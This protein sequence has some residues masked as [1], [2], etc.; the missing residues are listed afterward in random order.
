MLSDVIFDDMKQ[1][2][3]DKDQ[4]KVGTLRM[5]RSEI[6]YAEVAGIASLDDAAVIK[7]VQSSIKKRKV[8]AEQFTAADRS[9][10]ADKEMLEADVLSSYLPSQLSELELV[11]L[12]STIASSLNIIKGSKD[13]ASMGELMKN[14]MSKVGAGAEGKLVNSLVKS[15]IND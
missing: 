7:I 2:M 4:L 1:A 8:A 5:L 10:L 14:V 15:F 6:K 11:D 12:I 3:R 13:G 9:D